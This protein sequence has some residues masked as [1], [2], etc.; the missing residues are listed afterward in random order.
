MSLESPFAQISLDAGDSKQWFIGDPVDAEGKAWDPR[1]FT[2]GRPVDIAAPV[3]LSVIEKGRPVSFS[4][5]PFHLPVITQELAGVVA[6]VAGPDAQLIPATV[7]GRDQPYHILNVV[8]QVDC[9]DDG[10][11][12]GKRS[13]EDESP[14][15]KAGDFMYIVELGLDIDKVGDA[16][17]FRPIGWNVAMVLSSVLQTALEQTG[18]SGVIFRDVRAGHSTTGVGIEPS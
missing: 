4:L 1:E 6:A 8:R 3:T 10:L 7:S 17:I 18:L 9:I 5:G 16:Q 2:Y 13:K 12:I 11:T 14:R 15:S